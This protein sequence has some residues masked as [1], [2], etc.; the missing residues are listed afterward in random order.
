MK[1]VT[2]ILVIFGAIDIFAG[3]TSG[4]LTDSVLRLLQTKKSEFK[5]EQKITG[6]A[7]FRFKDF[8]YPV[9][10]QKIMLLYEDKTIL[11]GA[12]NLD[13]TFELYGALKKGKY[14]LQI[15]SEFY[16]CEQDVFIPSEIDN[17][18][19]ICIKRIR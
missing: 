1:Q 8:D 7:F 14:K 2:I 15:K 4:Q 19:L 17:Y 16:S 3:E 10:A 5:R 12:T 11:T 9:K 18:K 6:L 13:G